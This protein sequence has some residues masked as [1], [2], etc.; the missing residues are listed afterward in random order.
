MVGK[1]FHWA[2]IFWGTNHKNVKDM[3][4]GSMNFLSSFVINF[5]RGM[6]LHT[7]AKLRKFPLEMKIAGSDDEVVLGDNEVASEEY[8]IEPAPPSTKVD[9]SKEDI[10]KQP[11]KKR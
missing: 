3:F 1:P 8:N 6:G 9:K 10:M 4:K 5:Y 2:C 7:E 11:T